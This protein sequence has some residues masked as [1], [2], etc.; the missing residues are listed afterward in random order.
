MKNRVFGMM[1]AVAMLTALP[2][3]AQADERPE[4]I[5]AMAAMQRSHSAVAESNFDSRVIKSVMD[6][7]LNRDWLSGPNGNDGT[8][9]IQD[10]LIFA[11]TNLAPLLSLRASWVFEISAA[12]ALVTQ[13]RRAFEKE[14]EI[15][16]VSVAVTVGMNCEKEYLQKYH[17]NFQ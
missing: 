2:S 12:H 7:L 16:T 1:A 4:L 11:A 9:I 6:G 3:L 15:V 13:W 14:Q 10:R 5:V 8:K 17:L